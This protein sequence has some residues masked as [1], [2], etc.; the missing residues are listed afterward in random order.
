MEIKITTRLKTYDLV[1]LTAFYT[2]IEDL[3]LKER[4]RKLEREEVWK[5][6]VNCNKEEGKNLAEE[7]TTKVKIFVNPNKHYWRVECKE[8]SKEE[9][10][11]KGK[12]NG[13]Y[14]VEVLTWWKEDARVDSALKTLRVTWNYGDKIKEVRRGELWKLTVKASN[15]EEAKE[16]TEGII[17]TKSR[18]KGLIINPHSQSYTILK[19]EKL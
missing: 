11:F 5:I 18:D 14:L 17:V 15:W 6:L 12:G 4:L 9:G 7:F 13:E 16:I 19:I 8:E 2:L 1:A 3:G 10:E